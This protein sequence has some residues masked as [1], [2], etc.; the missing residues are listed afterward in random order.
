MDWI[1]V[2]DEFVLSEFALF[3]LSRNHSNSKPTHSMGF[4]WRFFANRIDSLLHAHSVLRYNKNVFQ[5]S[6]QSQ[7]DDLHTVWMLKKSFGTNLVKIK[8]TVKEME[9]L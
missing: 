8:I 4:C 9:Y 5:I 6:A 1:L 2:I 7:I 3:W